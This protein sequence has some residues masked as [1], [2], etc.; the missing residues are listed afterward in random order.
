MHPYYTFSQGISRKTSAKSES[1]LPEHHSDTSASMVV[2]C[3]SVM[4]HAKILTFDLE[5]LE[6]NCF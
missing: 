3:Q 5:A 2:M 4:L 6:L 1:V